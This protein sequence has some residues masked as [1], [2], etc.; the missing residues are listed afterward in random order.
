[1]N[2]ILKIKKQ[3]YKQAISTQGSKEQRGHID[4][5]NSIVHNCTTNNDFISHEQTFYKE[6]QFPCRVVGQKYENP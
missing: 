3:S 4:S 1:M 2:V 5:R 6:F